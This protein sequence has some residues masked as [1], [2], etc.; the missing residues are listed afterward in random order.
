MICFES[1]AEIFDGHLADRKVPPGTNT[2]SLG[3]VADVRL[4]RLEVD[5]RYERRTLRLDFEDPTG[6]AYTR[7]PVNDLAFL[8]FFKEQ[9]ISAL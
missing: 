2:R 1:V 3:T 9:E 4:N 6:K 5:D 8:G 7:L